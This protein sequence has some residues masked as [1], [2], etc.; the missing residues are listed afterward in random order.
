MYRIDRLQSFIDRAQIFLLLQKVFKWKEYKC[1]HCKP[2]SIP[3]HKCLKV[4]GGRRKE[5]GSVHCLH[6]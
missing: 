4:G 6:V 5:N 2:N 1:V 3:G